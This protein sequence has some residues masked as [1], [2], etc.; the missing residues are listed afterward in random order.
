MNLEESIERV[1]R[2]VPT[3][4]AAFGAVVG[5][6]AEYVQ[7]IDDEGEWVPPDVMLACLIGQMHPQSAVLPINLSRGYE[8]LV[9]EGEGAVEMSRTGLSNIAIKAADIG[10]DLGDDRRHCRSERRGG[11]ARRRGEADPGR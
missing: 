11:P 2:I 5:P 8:K 4:D 7:F 3:V 10:A 1:A 9:E 6:E